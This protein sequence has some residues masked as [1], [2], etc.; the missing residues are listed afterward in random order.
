[1]KRRTLLSAVGA[2][3]LIGPGW[4]A[5]PAGQLVSG[6]QATPG[7]AARQ[8]VVIVGGGWAGLSAARQLLSSANELDVLVIDRAPRLRALPLSNPWLVNRTPQRLPPLDLA[9]LAQSHGYRFV[10]ATVQTIDRAQ[11]QVHSSQGRFEYDWLVLA[12]GLGYDYETWFGQDQRAANQARAQFPA[13]FLA[14]ELDLLKEKLHDFRGGE[15]VMTVPPPPYRCPPAPYERAMMIGWW[16]KSQR[17][18]AKLTV[19]DAGGGLGRFTH[20]FTERY[21]DQI[22]FRPYTV[23]RGIDPFARTLSTEEGDLRF[24][25]AILLPPM[26]ANAL[27][28]QCGLLGQNTQGQASRWAGVDPAHLVSPVDDRVYLVGDLLDS[29]SPLFGHYPK[30]AHIAAHLGA[31]AAQQIAAR[32]RGVPPGTAALPH[33]ICHVWLDAQPP[34]QMQL[35]AQ[36]RLR[37]DGLIVQTP[38]QIDNPQ[39]RDEDL[40]WARALMA[41]QLGAAAP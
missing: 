27:V 15:L 11:R 26:R 23:I 31:A 17:I 35:E 20:L 10:S 7:G 38:R 22:D 30:T 40:Q 16:L 29:V 3:S 24:D 21:R 25:H 19:L 37:G 8:R 13:G 6:G 41:G 1:M 9:S 14:E 32:S 12:A 2:A 4:A 39:P 34:E 18:K 36:Y 28:A 5:A 33:S